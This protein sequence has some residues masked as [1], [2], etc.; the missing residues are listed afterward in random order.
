LR[1]EDNKIPVKDYF[2]KNW[3]KIKN[4]AAIL[5]KLT[6][7]IMSDH[8]HKILPLQSVKGKVKA[9]EFRNNNGKQCILITAEGPGLAECV[10]SSNK[11]LKSLFGH[12]TQN[13]KGKYLFKGNNISSD[14]LIEE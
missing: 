8:D 11:N 5:K 3:P 13:D 12:T 6:P 4:V 10:I 14:V 2:S 1:D 7:F 9:G